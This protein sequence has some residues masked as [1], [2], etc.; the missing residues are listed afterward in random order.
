VTWIG[1]FHDFL[2]R[3]DDDGG[4]IAWKYS[5]GVQG[6]LRALRRNQLAGSQAFVIFKVGTVPGIEEWL[7]SAIYTEL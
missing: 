3:K 5:R 2:K 1:P 7:K 6:A 4:V